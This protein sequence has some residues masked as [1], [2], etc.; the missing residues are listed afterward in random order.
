[1]RILLLLVV[2]VGVAHAEAPAD[3]AKKIVDAQLAALQKIDDSFE[4]TFAPGAVVNASD[5]Q[6]LQMVKVEEITGGGFRTSIHATKLLSLTAGGD[7]KV[8]WLAGEAELTTRTVTGQKDNGDFEY[9]PSAKHTIR[10]TEL[11]VADGAKW[12]VVA[13]QFAQPGAP[14][15]NTS[16]PTS[17]DNETKPDQLAKIVV[18]STALSNGLAKDATAVVFGTDKAERGI[19]GPAAKKLVDGWKSL[20][21][22][23]EG[24]VR[25]VRTATYGFVQANV[26]WVQPGGAPYRMRAL[27]IA[28]PGPTGTWTIRTVHYA[29]P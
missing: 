10:F 13:A 28:T 23:L 9:G 3:V 19:G 6:N 4:K 25:E 11:A 16:A 2:S 18:S 1:M 12:K 15:R 22:E 24:K 7:A 5:V 17:I 29:A 14:K 21:L 26:N 8:V 20:K 27:M